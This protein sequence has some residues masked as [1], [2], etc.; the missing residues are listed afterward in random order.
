MS[1]ALAF[2]LSS[3]AT[4]GAKFL[5]IWSRRTIF[6]VSHLVIG[7][8]LISA[9]YFTDHHLGIAAFICI[10]FCQFWLQI[11]TAPLFVY[12]TEVLQNNALGMVNAWRSIAFTWLKIFVDNI[13][14]SMDPLF[15]VFIGHALYFFGIIQLIAFV[16]IFHMLE[17]T[18]GKNNQEKRMVTNPI[19][20]KLA[21]LKK[22]R[23]NDNIEK[24]STHDSKPLKRK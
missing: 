16:V 9:G 17:E 24:L 14:T 11:L 19:K 4:A 1:G 18:K 20:M 23:F 13:V 22:L 6:C 3:G 10:F 5:H 12:Q 2:A 21:N 8:L 15:Y 7:I